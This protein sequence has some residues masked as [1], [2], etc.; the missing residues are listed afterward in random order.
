MGDKGCWICAPPDPTYNFS[1]S[2]TASGWASG[3]ALAKAGSAQQ[4]ASMATRRGTAGKQARLRPHLLQVLDDGERLR[5][6]PT[7]VLEGGKQPLRV[8][9]A[10]VGSVL[11]SA[12]L[13]QVDERRLVGEPFQVQRNSATIRCGRAEI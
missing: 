9:R 4:A 10:I 2:H 1:C 7:L 11:L 12:V 3:A 8:E 13:H 5:Q 6:H